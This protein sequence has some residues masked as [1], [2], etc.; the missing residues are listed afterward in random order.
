MK[1]K[2]STVREELVEKVHNES[3]KSKEAF[4]RISQLEME[5]V[6]KKAEIENQQDLRMIAEKQLEGIKFY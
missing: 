1:N 2:F 3:S 6:K 5:L 4:H